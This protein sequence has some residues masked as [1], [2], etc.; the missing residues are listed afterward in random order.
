MTG[1]LRDR[2]A[3]V[4]CGGRQGSGYLLTPYVVLTAAHLV[5]GQDPVRVTTPGSPADVP[6]GREGIWYTPER[7]VDVALV[8]C[9]VPLAPAVAFGGDSWADITAPAPIPRCEAIGF[10]YVQRGTG[11]QL[12]TEQVT[13]TYKPSGLF[14]GRDVLM[15]DGTPPAARPDDVSPWAGLSGAAVFAGR[16]LVGVVTGDPVGR[17]HGRVT[18]CPMHRMLDEHAFAVTLHDLGHT[19]ARLVAPPGQ[20]TD[21]AADFEFRYQTY[22]GK[23]D[24][25]PWCRRDRPL[26]PG[27]AAPAPR[28][29]SGR[30]RTDPRHQ[31]T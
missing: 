23:A 31:G 1:P 8:A 9:A 24:H 5:L 4:R 30:Q 25:Q 3:V 11:G 28:G 19:P 13:G 15:V 22:A 26:V 12:D 27:R 21:E 29:G 10:P 6:C 7:G 17:Q 16:A 18:V 14:S 20:L 2:L